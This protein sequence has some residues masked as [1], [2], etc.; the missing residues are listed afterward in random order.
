MPRLR[1]GGL[2]R[3][4]AVAALLALAAGIVLTD[5]PPGRP[6]ACTPAPPDAPPAGRVGFPLPLPDPSS[7]AVVHAGQQVDVLAPPGEGRPA[8]VVAADV[9]VLRTVP[10]STGGTGLLYL[11]VRP[12]QARA[13]ATLAPGV[14]VSVTVRAP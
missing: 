6:A 14:P 9:R 8:A 3:A 4:G 2:L 5:A 10:G 13:L 12:D 1:R 11:A 7:L